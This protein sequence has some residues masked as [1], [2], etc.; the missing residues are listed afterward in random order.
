MGTD[1]RWPQMIQWQRSLV[2]YYGYD[3]LTKWFQSIGGANAEWTANQAF[4]KPAIRF[5][6]HL[7]QILIAL[8]FQV[9]IDL[10]RHFRGG[11][12]APR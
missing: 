4:E 9:L 6:Y 10:I 1:P 12:I 8:F 5:V 11:S 7:E 2:N 3:K